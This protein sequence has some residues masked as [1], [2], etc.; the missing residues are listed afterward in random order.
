M[1]SIIRPDIYY[2]FSEFGE[3][4]CD[5]QKSPWSNAIEYEGSKNAAELHYI[6][7]NRFMIRRLKEEVLKDL[8]AK[9][10]Q[11]IYVETDVKL[12]KQINAILK[13]DYELVK[14]VSDNP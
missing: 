7:K 4:Y 10:R 14:G 8:P 11:R 12:S 6:L 9:Q 13:Q 5:P 1:L 3:R 2:K